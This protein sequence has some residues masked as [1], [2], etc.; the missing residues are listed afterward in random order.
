MNRREF[1]TL[2]GGV[3]VWPRAAHAQQAE[4]IR[5]V[6]VLIGVADNAQG[7]ARLTA[8]HRGMQELGW[9]EGRNIHFEPRFTEGDG[10]IGRAHV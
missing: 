5:Q 8:F 9:T 10:E 4:R 7:Q 3:A 2:L 6:G 1:I